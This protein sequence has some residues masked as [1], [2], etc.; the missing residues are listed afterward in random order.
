MHIPSSRQTRLAAGLSAALLV[1]AVTAVQAGTSTALMN[2]SATVPQSCSAAAGTLAFGEVSAAVL[3]DVTTTL[4]VTCPAGLAY[5]VTMDAG[6][7]FDAARGLRT[8]T[9]PNGAKVRYSI[10]KNAEGS[11]QWGDNDFA[12]TYPY[13]SSLSFTGTGAVQPIT[14]YGRVQPSG[15]NDLVFVAGDYSDQVVVTLNY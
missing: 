7:H 2:V 8:M 1:L 3:K 10:L 6:Q 5:K 9:G 14:V 4:S 13:G 15:N 11:G 12:A